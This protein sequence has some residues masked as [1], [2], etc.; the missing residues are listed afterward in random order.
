[1]KSRWHRLTQFASSW[2]VPAIIICMGGALGTAS[3]QAVTMVI[4]GSEQLLSLLLINVTGAFLLG[5]LLEWLQRTD[6]LNA[7]LQRIRLFFGTGFLGCFT[8]YSTFAVTNA[9]LIDNGYVPKAI[10]YGLLTVITGFLAAA[11]G[12]AIV[13]KISPAEE[14]H[15]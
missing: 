12:M 10:A 8:T 9:Q 6:A 14:P 7:H 15:S 11:I 1:M 3:R 5:M 13:S 2:W 4:P